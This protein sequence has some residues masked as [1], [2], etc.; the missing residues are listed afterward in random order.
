MKVQI[1]QFQRELSLASGAQ[2]VLEDRDFSKPTLINFEV[3][4]CPA[5]AG[6]DFDLLNGRIVLPIYDAYGNWVGFAGRKVDDYST[7]V[8]EYYQQKTTKLQGLDRFMKWKV[9][10]WVNTPYAKSNHLFNL[11]R[12]KRYIHEAGYCII[13]EGYFDVMRLSQLGFHN[14]VALSG[15][16][17]TETQC[18]LIYRYCNKVLIMLDG[19]DAGKIATNKTMERAR[20][21]NI[22]ANIV[23]LPDNL[24]PDDL[25]EETM[26]IIDS[27]VRT[28][29]EEMY[30]KL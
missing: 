13:V 6:Y 30:I 8:K 22:F 9:T 2:K 1:E 20:Q 26:K 21:N 3:G 27:E 18:D 16:S 24:D 7:K 11:N 17:L 4:F 5:Y 23:E 19:D 29:D 25:D 28:S 15:T 10:K 12:A 14:V